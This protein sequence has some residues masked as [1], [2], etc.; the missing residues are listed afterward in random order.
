MM[1]SSDKTFNLNDNCFDVIRI[2]CTFTV[3]S[4]HF[5]TDFGIRNE[6]LNGMAYFVRGVPVFFFLSGLFIA[7]SLERYNLREFLHRRVARIFPELWVCVLFNLALILLVVRAGGAD[8]LVYLATQLTIFQFYT[9]DWLRSYGVGVPNGALW[10]ITVDMQ[11]YIIAII[12]AK[13]LKTCKLKSWLGLILLTMLL[14]LILEKTHNLYPVLVYKL[15]YVNLISFMWIFLI[16]MCIYYHREKLVPVMIKHKY[17]LIIM[18]FVWQYMLPSDFIS[19]FESIRYNLVTTVIML[20]M[21]TGIGFSYQW[22]SKEDY[23]YSFYLY[24]IVVI[25]FVINNIGK[26]FTP[27]EYIIL[28]ACCFMAIAILAIISRTYVAGSLTRKF[29]E[30]I[31]LLQR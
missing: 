29:E 18:Y 9:G 12:M 14:S 7:R 27:V 25:N 15:L 4:G 3:F 23:S 31:L 26:D 1:S 6:L 11:F 28:F 10:T 8:I 21:F 20:C 22:R 19:I 13:T 2:I 30:K 17:Y 24:H 5:L 16:G